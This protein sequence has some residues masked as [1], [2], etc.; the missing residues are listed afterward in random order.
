MRLK[1]Y[2]V[3][4]YG[5]RV[6][7]VLGALMMSVHSWAHSLPGSQL[8]LSHQKD[9]P[10]ILTL[11]FPL[12][13]AIMANPKLA[14]LNDETVGEAIS[15]KGAHALGEYLSQHVQLR[16]G[17]NALPMTMTK[18]SVETGY[19]AHVGEFKQLNIDYE[20]PLEREQALPLLLNYDA[21]LHQIRSHKVDVYWQNPEGDKLRLAHFGY[22]LQDGKPKSY[23][24]TA[25]Q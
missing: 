16:Q 1:A 7:L 3:R 14:S 12:E 8:V 23:L 5:I 6:W 22:H 11:Q 15:Q 13:E 17:K 21:I 20:L 2:S 25:P 24:L 10:L 18:A 9:Q 4:G 19:N